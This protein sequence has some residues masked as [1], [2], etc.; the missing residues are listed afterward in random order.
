MRARLSTFGEK[1][2]WLSR[3]TCLLFT[4]SHIR[5][6][7]T[8]PKLPPASTFEL[9]SGRTSTLNPVPN[10]AGLT[11]DLCHLV[12]PDISNHAPTAFRL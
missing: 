11:F 1:R 9:F 4:E 7:N 8:A 3:R 12:F 6:R 5:T 2:T 10:G